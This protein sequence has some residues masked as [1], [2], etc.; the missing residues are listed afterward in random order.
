MLECFGKGLQ[1]ISV[2]GDRFEINQL[3]YADTALVAAQ[4]VRWPGILKDTQ[5]RVFA[6]GLLQQVLLFVARIYTVQYVELREYRP[7]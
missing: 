7:V 6:P 5:G 2:K 1:L 3:L 4:A